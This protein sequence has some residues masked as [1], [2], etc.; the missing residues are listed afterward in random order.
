MLKKR[1]NISEKTPAQFR[2]DLIYRLGV[3]AERHAPTVG[4]VLGIGKA[5]ASDA[6]RRKRVRARWLKTRAILRYAERRATWARYNWR[7][8]LRLAGID[9]ATL[10]P[11]DPLWAACWRRPRGWLVRDI[12]AEMRAELV[13]AGVPESKTMLASDEKIEELLARC[14]ER[15]RV[16]ALGL[17]AVRAGTFRDRV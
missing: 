13:A 15:M 9:P 3:A 8:R 4:Y 6:L 12:A 17:E 10:R 7:R 2:A 16:D 14:A 1:R 11:D 5:G